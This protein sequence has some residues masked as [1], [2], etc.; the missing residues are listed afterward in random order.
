VN[1]LLTKHSPFISPFAQKKSNKEPFNENSK[2][3]NIDA[4]FN[5]V[6]KEEWSNTYVLG[7]SALTSALRCRSRRTRGWNPWENSEQGK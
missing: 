4:I 7:C 3:L 2:Q 1:H 6:T 5:P